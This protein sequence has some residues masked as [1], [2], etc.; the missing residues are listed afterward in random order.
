MFLVR[1]REEVRD[2]EPAQTVYQGGLLLPR[3]GVA[4]FAAERGQ[5]GP[6]AD[7]ELVRVVA[8]RLQRIARLVQ[9]VAAA[10]VHRDEKLEA[11]P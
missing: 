11:R 1:C 2:E 10:V 3:F 9:P 5:D 4:A 6:A 8:E 7:P